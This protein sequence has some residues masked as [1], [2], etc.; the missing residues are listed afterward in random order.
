MSEKIG[1]FGIIEFLFWVKDLFNVV[2]LL[3]QT[4]QLCNFFEYKDYFLSITRGNTHCRE[5]RKLRKVKEESHP[6]FTPSPV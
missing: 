3:E 6:W 4:F 5:I 1:W 2:S